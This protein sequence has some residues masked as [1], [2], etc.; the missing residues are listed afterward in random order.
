MT[1]FGGEA[2][3]SGSTL[4]WVRSFAWFARI[5]GLA[6]AGDS[7]TVAAELS[8]GPDPTLGG[9]DTVVAEGLVRLW[10]DDTEGA[11]RVLWGALVRARKG[12]PLRIGQAHGFLAEAEYRLGR[13]QEAV[14][15]AES[16]AVQAEENGRYWDLPLLHGIACYPLAARAEWEAAEAHAL[17]ANSWAELVTTASAR[18]AAVTARYIIAHARDNVPAM[19]RGAEVME[20][21]IAGLEPGILLF[22][23]VRA[24]ALSRLDR[25]ADARAALEPYAALAAATGR[26]SAAMHVPRVRGQIAAAEQRLEDAAGALRTAADLARELGLPLQYGLAEL[27]LAEA[28]DAARLT[29]AAAAAL[30]AAIREFSAMDATAYVQQAQAFGEERAPVRRRTRR[31][32]RRAD[33]APAAGRRTGRGHQSTQRLDRPGAAPVA[34]DGR[35]PPD[36]RLRHPR[37]PQP[38]RA[39]GSVP[40]PRRDHERGLTTAAP[41]RGPPDGTEGARPRKAG[42]SS[43]VPAP[44]GGPLWSHPHD[45]ESRTKWFSRWTSTS[46]TPAGSPAP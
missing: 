1:R 33:P 21:M 9:L 29:K 45:A 12:E 16:A 37:R 8:R 32:L 17:Q 10:T 4:P 35:G 11:E 5:A 23:P 41:S 43:D 42:W 31:S 28:L 36:P 46:T 13:L 38:R 26:R 24:D 6:L 7:R 40:G 44:P 20:P 22:G 25:P 30:A 34:Q 27:R 3:A 18:F 14:T 2:I 15:D 39:A 19:L